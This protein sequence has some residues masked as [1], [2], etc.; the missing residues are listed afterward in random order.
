M[1]RRP[2]VTKAVRDLARRPVGPVQRADLS[3]LN[4]H[5]VAEAEWCREP[6]ERFRC[7]SCGRLAALRD[8]T[9]SPAAPP[10]H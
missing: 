4:C 2:G 6:P 1:A 5:A 9:A 10:I 7:P 8:D 3:C